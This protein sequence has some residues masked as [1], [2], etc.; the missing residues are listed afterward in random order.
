LE[1][2]FELLGGDGD[3]ILGRGQQEGDSWLL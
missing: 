2:I 1:E 3:G